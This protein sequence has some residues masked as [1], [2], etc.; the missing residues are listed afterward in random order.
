MVDPP[1]RRPSRRRVW[2]RLGAEPTASS[3]GTVFC[4]AERL[5]RF[6]PQD[7]APVRLHHDADPQAAIDRPVVEAASEEG[8]DGPEERRLL[9]P[10]PRGV[11]AEPDDDR[12]PFRASVSGC[13][14]DHQH[15]LPAGES[16]A[17]RAPDI[18]VAAAEQAA[19]HYEQNRRD[20][21]P[22]PIHEHF[23]PTLSVRRLRGPTSLL[24]LRTLV[25]DR[26]SRAST[27]PEP[28]VQRGGSR[29]SPTGRW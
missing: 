27:W 17:A 7:R 8:A 11:G 25:H 3:T 12:P 4:E 18:G 21:I 28:E 13:P 2:V 22:L 14:I 15:P 19:H 29:Y 26:R 16:H 24:E 20:R 6:G 1:D 10:E 9:G 5:S 23:V